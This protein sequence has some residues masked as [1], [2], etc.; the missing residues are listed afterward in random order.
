MTTAKDYIDSLFIF[1]VVIPPAPLC[2]NM[3][4]SIV[5]EYYLCILRGR[6]QNLYFSTECGRETNTFSTEFTTIEKEKKRRMWLGS[7]NDIVVSS[8][9]EYPNYYRSHHY[10]YLYNV[11]R[12]I[13]THIGY[14]GIV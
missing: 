4:N 2:L 7:Y 8:L 6:K 5:R 11:V 14:I 3:M 12:T 1:N 13:H 10:Y 9:A